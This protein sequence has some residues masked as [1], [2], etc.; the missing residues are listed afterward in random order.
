MTD[1]KSRQGA[2][3]LTPLEMNALAVLKD[4]TVITFD[5]TPPPVKPKLSLQAKKDQILSL[6]SCMLLR[7]NFTYLSQV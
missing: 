5:T 3:K 4:Y 6:L 7:M 2:N 1:R